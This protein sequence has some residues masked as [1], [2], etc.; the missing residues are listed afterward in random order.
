MESKKVHRISIAVFFVLVLALLYFRV[1]E[2]GSSIWPKGRVSGD[3]N[4][5]LVMGTFARIVAVAM[6][7]EVAIACMEAGFAELEAVDESMSDYKAGS[8]LSRLNAEGFRVAVS[9][10]DALFEVLERSVEYSKKSGGGFDVTV[11]AIVDL[12]R[13]AKEKGERPTEE[14]IAAAKEKVGYEKLVLDREKKTVRFAVDGMRIDLGGIAKGYAID[15]AILAMKKG[16]AIGGMVDVGGD[17]RCFGAP[18]KG[19]DVWLVGL[20]DPSVE[21][22]DMGPGKYLLV[23]KLADAAIATSGDYRRF[24]MV[25]GEKYSHIIT[26]SS[27]EGA[28]KLSSVTIISKT[29]IDADALA[30]S[31]SVLGAEKGLELIEGERQAEAIL[32]TPGPE[33]EIIKSSG[34]EKYLHGKY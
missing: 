32:I 23:L 6:D 18:G 20:Q 4:Q 27:G 8:E 29:A 19:K 17:I 26:P 28:K 24:V 9:V 21:K 11:G 31:V 34:A 22:D 2:G 1:G 3:S 7:R 10:S 25:D 15:E 13:G 5:R 16:G 14:E 30:T 33:Y 12:F